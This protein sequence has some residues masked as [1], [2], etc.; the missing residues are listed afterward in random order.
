MNDVRDF[1]SLLNAP[2]ELKRDYLIVMEESFKIKDWI[3]KE[4][5]FNEE[6]FQGYFLKKITAPDAPMRRGFDENA[7]RA[8]LQQFKNGLLSL[9]RETNYPD[10]AILAKV[11]VYS[12]ELAQSHLSHHQPKEIELSDNK[13]VEYH[14]SK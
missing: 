1:V 4:K 6:E 13:E 8:V 5:G 12:N 7:L 3:M 2:K 9:V 14:E 11:A 10:E